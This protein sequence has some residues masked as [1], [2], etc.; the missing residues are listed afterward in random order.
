MSPVEPFDDSES[1]QLWRVVEADEE[2]VILE[3]TPE[4]WGWLH[5]IEENVITSDGTYGHLWIKPREVSEADDA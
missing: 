5:T 4:G 1:I 3:L 2:R